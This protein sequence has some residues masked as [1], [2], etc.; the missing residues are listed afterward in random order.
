LSSSNYQIVYVNVTWCWRKNSW[1]SSNYQIVYVIVTWYSRVNVTW[2]SRKNS[3]LSSNYQIVYVNVLHGV[4][5]KI[6]ESIKLKLVMQI[7]VTWCREREDCLSTCHHR[8]SIDRI[9]V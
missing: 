9:V 5:E 8:R 4:G 6:A 7:N 2:C 1:L 3:W